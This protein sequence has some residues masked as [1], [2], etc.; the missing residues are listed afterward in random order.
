MVENF[1][2]EGLQAFC[3][4]GSR[5][6]GS[7]FHSTTTENGKDRLAKSGALQL[8]SWSWDTCLARVLRVGR[9]FWMD[10]AGGGT[11]A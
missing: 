8:G 3:M 11:M 1:L 7:V 2:L 6:T 10:V 4:G 5:S 9:S